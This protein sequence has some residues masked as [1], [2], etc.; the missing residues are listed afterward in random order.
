MFKTRKRKKK[1]KE[2]SE[3]EEE[4]EETLRSGDMQNN[5][6]LDFKC[7]TRLLFFP[8]KSWLQKSRMY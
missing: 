8:I 6:A 1:E 3:E 7:P 4:E 2:R 5:L